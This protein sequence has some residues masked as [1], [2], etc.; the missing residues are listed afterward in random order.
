MTNIERLNE[1]NWIVIVAG[2]SATRFGKDKLLTELSGKPLILHTVEKALKACKNVVLVASKDN[3]QELKEL[4]GDTVIFTL[5]GETRTQSVKNGLERVPTTA[6]LV[7]IQDGARPFASCELY[8]KLFQSAKIHG[9]AIPIIKATDTTYD[10]SA[11]KPTVIDRN[12]LASA[13]TPQV[14][15]VNKLKKAYEKSPQ[16]TD[17]GQVW[18]KAYG[19]LHFEEGERTNIKIT[20]PQDLPKYRIG[21]GFDAHRLK[22]GRKLFLCGVNVPYELGLDGHSD[23]DVALH[24]LCDAILSAIGEKDIG[25]IFPD[26]DEKYRDADSSKLLEEVWNI[27][28][29][30]GYA[31]ENASITIMA[32]K[33]KLSPFVMQMRKRVAEI[34]KGSIQQINVSATT[35][36]NLGVTAEGKGMACYANVLLKR[37]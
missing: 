27:A 19:E 36:E 32:Q 28:T 3:L 1:D 20:Y 31:L 24:A 16:E 26:T 25:N 37:N 22:E 13:Q 5:G 30:K 35:T 9:N 33:P 14:F 29:R 11:K 12:N 21:V 17:D 15:D 7:A 23:A 10:I 6:K 4:L 34:L 8:L 18:L 2:G